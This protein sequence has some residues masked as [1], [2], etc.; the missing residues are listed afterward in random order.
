MN[1]L[2]ILGLASQRSFLQKT[3]KL[4]IPY[5]AVNVEDSVIPV[6]VTN[7]SG[8][9]GTLKKHSPLGSLKEI[10]DILEDFDHKVFLP[11]DN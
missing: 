5:T 11:V 7:L 6:Q 9:F 2:C 3:N 10:T 8:S 4:I 1:T